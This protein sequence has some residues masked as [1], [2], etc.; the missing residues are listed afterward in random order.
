[1]G[2]R[3][4]RGPPPHRPPRRTRCT[5]MRTATTEQLGVDSSDQGLPRVGTSR[6]TL[7]RTFRSSAVSVATTYITS[8]AV[9]PVVLRHLGAARYGVWAT[10]A[11]VLAVG[12]LADA[13][14]RT[15]IVRRVSSAHGEGSS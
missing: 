5:A 12:G 10:V 15:E 1:M 2:P 7:A 9:L 14:I 8:L 6:F 11:S 4:S 3:L 13:G